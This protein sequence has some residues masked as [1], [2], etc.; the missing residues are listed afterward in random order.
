MTRQRLAI[1]F[2]AALAILYSYEILTA[3]L[4]DASVNGLHVLGLICALGLLI[5]ELRPTK[6][7]GKH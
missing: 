5:I 7:T 1:F 3:I 2:A 4:N 6:Q